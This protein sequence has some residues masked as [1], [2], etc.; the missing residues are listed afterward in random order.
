MKFRKKI[1]ISSC[2]ALSLTI[3]AVAT[4]NYDVLNQFTSK[5]TIEIERSVESYS[6]DN[7][8][9]EIDKISIEI[10]R[11]MNSAVFKTSDATTSVDINSLIPFVTELANRKHGLNNSEIVSTITDKSKTLTARKVMVDLYNL[12]N[13]GQLQNQ[14]LKL[15]LKD[16]SIENELKTKIVAASQFVKSDIDVLK[17]LIK[18]D[19]GI[20]GFQSLKQISRV[21]SSEAYAIASQILANKETA[22]NEMLSAALKATSNYFAN[23]EI[24]QSSEARKTKELDRFIDEGLNIMK[25]TNDPILSDSAFFS[26]SNSKSEKA[27]IKIINDETIEISLKAHA[28]EQNYYILRDILNNSPSSSEIKT[29]AE[30]MKILPVLDLKE[31]LEKVLTQ[32]EDVEMINIINEALNR[33]DESGIKGNLKYND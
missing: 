23:Q 28:I 4:A 1:L 16:S 3:G 22:T 14:E 30:G 25:S 21:D 17:E 6:V 26:I 24:D 15:L 5:D 10:E 19:K 7:L 13:E 2:F 29:V 31:P 18:Q 9:D 27:I 12:K 33:I 11:N 32:I 20:L 8:L